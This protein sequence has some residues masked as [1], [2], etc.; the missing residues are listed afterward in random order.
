MI[1]NTTLTRPQDIRVDL[2]LI[3]QMVE[4]GSRVLDVGC[5]DGTLL[6]HLVETKQ[7]DGRGIE[8]SQAGVNACV[9]KGLSVV[10]GDADADLSDYP[11]KGF[12]YAILSQTLQATHRPKLVME[13]LLRVGKKAVVSFPNFAY[14]RCRTYLAF[15]GRMPMTSSL[16]YAWYET[17]NI[18]FCTLRDFTVLCE[19]L[20]IRIQQ[21]IIVGNDGKVL[22]YPFTSRRANFFAAQCVFMLES[23]ENI[24]FPHHTSYCW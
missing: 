10:Q 8:L 1:E 15:K 5:A 4:P 12:D 13:Q 16:D 14:W 22:S 17:P 18:H 6:S 21:S 2:Q 7:V 20:N 11:D 3:A 23:Q 9:R 24:R 19:E